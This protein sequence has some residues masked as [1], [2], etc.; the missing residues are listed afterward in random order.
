MALN[1][2]IQ[3]IKNDMKNLMSHNEIL[4]QKLSEDDRKRQADISNLTT[5]LHDKNLVKNKLMTTLRCVFISFKLFPIIS[6]GNKRLETK[7]K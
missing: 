1:A 6:S 2:Y 5:Q 7:S 3:H 4:K